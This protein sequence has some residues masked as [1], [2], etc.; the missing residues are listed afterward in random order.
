MLKRIL[1]SE[2]IFASHFLLLAKIHF[3]INVL[4][5]I[6]TKFQAYKRI[7]V[8]KYLHSSKYLLLIASYYIGKPFTSLW[9]RLIFGSFWKYSIHFASKYSIWSKINKYSLRKK[10]SLPFLF[11]FHVKSAYSLQFASNR[12]F[13]RTL[14][15]GRYSIHLHFNALLFTNEKNTSRKCTWNKH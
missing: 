14:L 6:F 4:N 3:K 12:I 2:R 15:E 5:R 1:A 7:I 10:Y 9:P 13:R 11:V 8:C